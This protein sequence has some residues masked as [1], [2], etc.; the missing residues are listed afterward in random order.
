MKIPRTTIIYLGLVLRR[1]T[2][3][4]KS[5]TNVE[6]KKKGKLPDKKIFSRI[7]WIFFKAK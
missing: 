3:V 7:V 1:A 6:L 5:M 2:L 4:P